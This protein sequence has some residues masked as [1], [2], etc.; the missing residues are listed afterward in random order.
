[1]NVWEIF[2]YEQGEIELK[3]NIQYS[4]IKD[5]KDFTYR[6]ETHPDHQSG[7]VTERDIQRRLHEE[8]EELRAYIEE[9]ENGYKIRQELLKNVEDA[10]RAYSAAMKAYDTTM[11]SEDAVYEAAIAVANAVRS[12]DMDAVDCEANFAYDAVVIAKDALDS[13]DKKNAWGQ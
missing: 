9:N 2:L 7:M 3:K 13:H 5:I 11:K 6:C 4:D 12:A 10:Q 1:M 8:I